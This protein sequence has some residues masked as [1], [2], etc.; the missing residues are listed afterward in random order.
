MKNVNIENMNI[1]EL[2]ALAYDIIIAIQNDQNVLQQV[3]QQIAKLQK[4]QEPEKKNEMAINK[5]IE[6]DTGMEVSHHVFDLNF[7]NVHNQITV[8]WEKYRN[9][10]KYTD[11]KRPTE[12]AESFT[13]SKI[14][15][16][17]LKQNCLRYW[18]KWKHLC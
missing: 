4:E 17:L 15:R 3:N 5:T 13:S 6:L 8:V 2:K 11:G 18:L 12:V 16:Q 1:Q 10:T 7:D 9:A 14:F